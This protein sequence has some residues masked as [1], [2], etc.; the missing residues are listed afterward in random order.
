MDDPTELPLAP[1][2]PPGGPR[3]TLEDL[4]EL[5]VRLLYNGL[6]LHRGDFPDAFSGS[7]LWK[8]Q[9]TRLIEKFPLDFKQEDMYLETQRCGEGGNH[10]SP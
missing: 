2:A 1:W 7:T 9:L 4:T 5:D 8:E 6:R 10:A 3:Y